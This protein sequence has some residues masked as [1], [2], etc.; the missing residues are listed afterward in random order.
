M[1]IR[2]PT[3]ATLALVVACTPAHRDRI[4]PEGTTFDDI[5]P[6]EVVKLVGTEP[7]WGL[8]VEGGEGLWTTPTNYPG[9]RF[10]LTRFARNGGFGFTGMLDGQSFTATLTPGECNDGMSDRTFPYVATVALGRST[11][12]G[13][14]YTDSRPFTGDPPR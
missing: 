6:E 12:H 9:T 1:R 5:A 2:L 14:G 13:C 7:F 8:R 3:F 4:D 10:A 11:L